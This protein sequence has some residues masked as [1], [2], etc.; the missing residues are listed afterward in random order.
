MKYTKGITPKHAIICQIQIFHPVLS[1]PIP[2]AKTVMNEK[3]HSPSDPAAPPICRY[4]RGA[5]CKKVCVSAVIADYSCEATNLRSIEPRTSNPSI[6]VEEVVQNNECD[7]SPLCCWGLI[8]Q[9]NHDSEDHNGNTAA[10][11]CPEHY[12]PSSKLFDGSRGEVCANSK[13]SVHNSS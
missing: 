1:T 3:S 9:S 12:L 5:I 2:P 8:W 11:S 10:E 6:P 4:R 7:C 13:N